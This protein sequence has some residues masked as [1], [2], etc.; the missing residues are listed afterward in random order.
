MPVKSID[1]AFKLLVQA[2]G[3]RYPG[4]S[5][6]PKNLWT[7]RFKIG[8]QD[9]TWIFST[10]LGKPEFVSRNLRR[11]L[12]DEFHY[13]WNASYYDSEIHP[14]LMAI[15]AEYNRTHDMIF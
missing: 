4:E 15:V 1:L 3:G 13:F 6:N 11:E 5:R 9:S 12:E 8:N 10:T 14:K 2:P 7:F